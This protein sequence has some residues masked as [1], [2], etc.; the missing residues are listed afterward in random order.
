[1]A[2]QL[3]VTLAALGWFPAGVVELREHERKT[4]REQAESSS[5]KASTLFNEVA[6]RFDDFAPTDAG[7]PRFRAKRSDDTVLRQRATVFA[8]VDAARKRSKSRAGE[9]VWHL[10]AKRHAVGPT[11]LRDEDRFHL[12]LEGEPSFYCFFGTSTSVAVAVDAIKRDAER[13]GDV[14]V[15]GST[16]LP[17]AASFADLHRDGLLTPFDVVDV[18]FLRGG[19]VDDSSAPPKKE[20]EAPRQGGGATP[21]PPP[22]QDAAPACSAPS[23]PLV[24]KFQNEAYPVGGLDPAVATV[25]DLRA[26][27]AKLTGLDATA[28]KLVCKDRLADPDCLLKDTKLAPGTT[29]VVLRGKATT[30]GAKQQKKVL[31]SSKR[32]A[33]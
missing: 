3:P 18:K 26:A 31:S 10:L 7:A 13:Q 11:H 16:E 4:S 15:V 28:Q 21:P 19:H 12:V 14:L 20:E 1:V 22:S 29:I 2:S 17:M 6:R 27:I 24:V 25:A 9:T 8:K 30:T 23:L 32:R 33:L 5:F